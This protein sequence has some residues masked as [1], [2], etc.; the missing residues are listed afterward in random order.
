[1][2]V[3]V[4]VA[5]GRALGLVDNKG[6]SMVAVSGCDA[7]VVSNY[8]DAVLALSQ[9]EED[10]EQLYLSIFNSPSDTGVSGPE[11]LL[12]AF[13]EYINRWVDGAT[14][15]KL[16]VNTAVHS[17]FL[18]PCEESYRQ[19][20]HTIFSQH[21]GNYL[22]SIPVIST[23]TGEV[24]SEPYT[25]DYL[26][27][28]IR[29]PVLFSTA[30]PL[31]VDR[32]GELTT[33]VEISPH[34]VLSQS[35]GAHDSVGT[36][37]R[38]PS[39]KH[40]KSGASARTEIDFS[41]L[42][43]YP[44]ETLPD[45][46]YP[47]N[48]KLWLY[49]NVT[50]PPASYQRWLLPPTRA[51]NST[52]LR[53]G[54]SNPEPWMAEHVVDGS[55]LIPASAYVEMIL[56]FPGVT[57]VWDCRFEAA[58]ILD[59]FVPPVTLE[60]S[61]D[62]VDWFVRSSTALQNMQGNFEWAR[63]GSPPFDIVHA[64]GK[65]SYEIPKLSPNL[66][67]HLNKDEF[68]KRS[69]Y[70]T[71][72]ELYRKL[73][74]YSQFGP[75]F[76]RIER[77]YSN[78]KE[79]LAW[80]RG[81]DEITNKTDYNIHPAILD[82]VF[83]LPL[84]FEQNLAPTGSVYLPRS[85]KRAFR[86]DG[87]PEPLSLPEEFCAYAV[88]VE[89]TPTYWSVDEYILDEDGMVI[90]TIEGLRFTWVEQ[91]DTLPAT[92]FTDCWQPHALPVASQKDC[93]I[94]V[95][96][97]TL[98]SDVVE[99]LRGLDRLA[100]SYT[101]AMLASLPKD[102]IPESPA[103][104]HYFT[105]CKNLVVNIDSEI[106]RSVDETRFKNILQSTHTIGR[107][108]KGKNLLV[109]PQSASNLFSEDDV[110]N[111]VYDGQ[112]LV[113]TVLS[114]FVTQFLDL[115][116][117]AIAAGKRVI[118][119]LEI[120]ARQGYLTK[121]LG[122][123]L[124][125]TSFKP[126]YYVDYVCSDTDLKSAQIA[127]A[128][129][130]WMTTSPAVFDPTISVEEQTLEPASFDIIVALD[131]LHKYS[132]TPDVLTNLR[133]M[134]VPGGYLAAVQWDATSFSKSAIGAKWINFIFGSEMEFLPPFS[135][136]EVT[137]N[138]SGYA[139]HIFLAQKGDCIG[140]IA[141][142]SQRSKFI[143]NRTPSA[144]SKQH[145]PNDL[146]VIRHFSAGDEPTLVAFLSDLSLTEPYSIWLH[147]DTTPSNAALVGL[148]R[149]LSQEFID[150]KIST[151]L[152]HPS[153]DV[154]RQREFIY[155]QL[156]PLKFVHAE[157]TV[158][159]LGALS[160]P[161]VIEAPAYPTTEP[162]GSKAV[163]F[164]ESKIWRHYPSILHEKDVEV[165]VSFVSMT[166]LFTG[167]SE[168]S[169]VVTAVGKLLEENGNL[170]GKRVVGIV[171]E[172]NGNVI[173]CPR[174]KVAVIPDD[175]SLSMAAALVGRLAFISFLKTIPSNG[176]HAILHA[177]NCSAVSLTTFA[178]LKASGFEILVTSTQS[179][180]SCGGKEIFDATSTYLSKDYRDWV[181]TVRKFAPRGIDLAISFDSDP[182]VG[183]ETTR[184]LAASGTFVQ[185]GAD[186]PKQLSRGQ[187]YISV[188]YTSL[189]EETD[190]Q[191]LDV[192]AVIRTS[193]SPKV[194][195]FD[196]GNLSTAHEKV[197][198]NP[199]NTS[200]LLGLE[201]IDP[202]LPI[203]RPGLIHGT[204]SF[205]PR[206]TYILI[207]GL[208]GLGMSLANFMVL[209]GARRIVVTSRSGAK[210]SC[211]LVDHKHVL[212]HIRQS[213]EDISFIREKNIV[214]YLRSLPDVIVDVI[215]MDCLD[216]AGTKELFA[217][218][219]HPIAGV[220]FLPA[221]LNDQ[222]FVNLK[223]EE[224]W[225][226]VYDV[227]IKGLR[228]LLEAVDPASLDFLVVTSTAAILSG[229]A[230]VNNTEAEVGQTNYTAAQYQLAAMV[231]ELPNTVCVAVPPVLD[232]G[233]LARSMNSLAGAR[234][235][236]FEKL[237]FF[238]VGSRQ[239]VQ[240]CMDAILSLGTKPT[241]SLYIPLMDYKSILDFGSVPAK[242]AALMRHLVAKNETDSIV[243][244]G[245]YEGT[246]RAACAKVLSISVD[247]IEEKVSLSSYGLDSL[248]AARLKGAL[249]AEF[250]I[251]VTQLQLLSTYM[252]VER[253]LAI[254]I[255]QASAAQR[256]RNSVKEQDALASDGASMENVMNET[257]VPLN[258][259]KDG[260]P[261]FFIHGA[262]G[263]VLVLRK[264]MQKVQVPVYGIQD[265]PEAPLTG[266]LL[267]LSA[268][269]LEKIRQKQKTGPYRIGGT[270]V[271]FFIAQMLRSAGET[272][273]M[274][275]MLD[276]APMLYR[277]PEMQEHVRRTIKDGTVSEDVSG[278]VNHWYKTLPI[279]QQLQI[280]DLVKDMATSG[281]LDDA[282]DI[283]LQFEEHFKAENK[284]AK[285]VARFCQAYVAHVLMSIRE[286]VNM[287]R[288]EQEGEAVFAWS[289]KRTVLMRAENGIKTN[290]RTHKASNAWDMD[291][292]TDNV[293]VY[294]FPGTHFGF[295]NP[296][297][298]LGEALND[299]LMELPG[300]V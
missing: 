42:N 146:T 214:Q 255:E 261:A 220:F 123:K 110:I 49:A 205:N 249:K 129:S 14:A 108:Q 187:R 161:R 53:V 27:K 270:V 219:E 224:D 190:L 228:A 118:R 43:G 121:L 231:K 145:H 125:D 300:S 282:E 117:A 238:G 246:V 237:K 130:P 92:R 195:I 163:R 225:N 119:V 281:S 153:W 95:K 104:R 79:V 251:E 102:F 99:L 19:E 194:E 288:R 120:G 63:E 166:P 88:T 236:A 13:A 45:I 289:V 235:T 292:L 82:A 113:D 209:N 115:V 167:C 232:F 57:E 204:V 216:V 101:K 138:S 200:V 222:L 37:Y 215:S 122:Q 144:I 65:L 201:N 189:A 210:A 55:N 293:E 256:A 133:Y 105:C 46:D 184:I 77:Y 185:V 74:S 250:N 275:I 91:E 93:P 203:T 221:R 28:S 239:A 10:N 151:V 157:L 199:L 126:G 170:I 175:L 22:P 186:L 139:N 260:Q 273:E 149:S 154:S 280:L 297:S 67:T 6:G 131:T 106:L 4:A 71:N 271:A 124:V 34:P 181:A 59:E 94:S 264:I 152:F 284:G 278:I 173:V 23:V 140:H 226:T 158:D 100:V 5:R 155:E 8:V 171:S 259:I 160:V 277:S 62:G 283:L 38:P 298:G 179:S 172:H 17:P 159:E 147:T 176:R 47:F 7:D 96:T 290:P 164:D 244:D 150:W 197:L 20:L 11:G 295:L 98:E 274:F 258:D 206:A 247:E 296:K 183:V 56:E 227:K 193:L 254:Q 218:M 44:S 291:K 97:Y 169:G 72:E 76:M 229:N 83:Q 51:L 52:R 68:L 48:K 85:L 109:S 286:S 32:Y 198:T 208:G 217:N 234:A 162:R 111:R 165:A 39:S 70:S 192:P 54:P 36:G 31:I 178:F 230:G 266:T 73:E 60:V 89:W 29:Q 223:T 26:W 41:L 243:K 25:V 128:L 136:W 1:M 174:S 132:D 35:M 141:F 252:T 276:G 285:W 75:Q 61:K 294:E 24:V 269:Y 148:S 16:R 299:L 207:G 248:T 202:E 265:T 69:Q 213:L 2:A 107:N 90:F 168:F 177:G 87:K 233:I 268:F 40:L 137:L 127:T 84:V 287:S 211:D 21:P 196:L 279:L 143:E 112:S 180:D 182:S 156:I 116:N 3:K 15:R 262:G 135:E 64:C 86:N 272:V 9:E 58:C 263:G 30:I 50:A 12:Q 134:L 81:Y 241:N 267:G 242:T 114:G 253:L 240:Q 191:G 66:I 257:V 78:G 33:F 245:T 103:S 80:I 212:T 18:A 188:D 142:I